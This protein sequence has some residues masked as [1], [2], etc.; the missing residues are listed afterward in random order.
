M[1]GRWTSL[2]QMGV[3][4]LKT[5]LGDSDIKDKAKTT[6]CKNRKDRILINHLR[7]YKH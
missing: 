4:Y 7:E 5:A 3:Q 1:I 6:V 2:Y